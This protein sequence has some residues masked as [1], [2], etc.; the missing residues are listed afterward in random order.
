MDSTPMDKMEVHL[1]AF[2][3]GGRVG[4]MMPDGKESILLSPGPGD[5]SPVWSPDGAMIAFTRLFPQNQ[6]GTYVMKADGSGVKKVLDAA[7]YYMSPIWAP[8]GQRLAM[9]DH[10]PDRRGLWTVKV[11]GTDP[12]Q[13][14]KDALPTE[15]AAWSPD[16]KT[17][18]FTYNKQPT[19]GG[20]YLIDA[21]GGEPKLVVDVPNG[22]LYRA[23]AVAWSPDGTHLAVRSNPQPAKEGHPAVSPMLSLVKVEKDGGAKVMQRVSGL[24]EGPWVPAWHLSSYTV[25]ALMQGSNGRQQLAAV[26]R[27]TGK[28][29][30]LGE[31]ARM[32]SPVWSADGGT[33][34]APAYDA[35]DK[36]RGMIMQVILKD[37]SM[38]W[39]MSHDMTD[40]MK[41]DQMSMMGNE[42]QIAVS[43]KSFTGSMPSAKPAAEAKLEGLRW[44]D[45]TWK[46]FT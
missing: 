37:P 42:T 19:T 10:D 26:S 44:A 30:I 2:S 17:I 33:L 43:P 40:L 46:G 34:M 39:D 12:K 20:L 35:A 27:D 4:V 3:Q 25:A 7:S 24:A 13:I 29:E 15:A 14:F 21:N 18:A 32:R 16:G 5:Y 6:K 1:L 36:P 22:G 45:M 11:D 38:G 23:G 9:N 28:V 8:D 31:Q 41:P